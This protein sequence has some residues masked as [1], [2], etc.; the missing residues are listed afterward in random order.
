[1]ATRCVRSSQR[2]VFGPRVRQSARPDLQAMITKRCPVLKNPLACR[3]MG[4]RADVVYVVTL[5]GKVL[6]EGTDA[7]EALRISQRM[8]GAEVQIKRAKG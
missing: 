3:P 4:T 5:G 2:R 1:M 7:Q 8:K 6:Y